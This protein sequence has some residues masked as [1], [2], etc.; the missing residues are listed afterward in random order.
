MADLEQRIALTDADNTDNTDNTDNVNDAGSSTSLTASSLLPYDTKTATYV[1]ASKIPN[2]GDGL[3]V[4]KHTARGTPIAVY[5]GAKIT[6]EEVFDLHQSDFE[7]YRQAN[8]VIRGTPN[9]FAVK[10]EKTDKPA[11]HGVYVNDAARIECDKANLTKEAIIEYAK[12]AKDCNVTTQNTSD[13]PVYV[14]RK[15][16]A[17]N[18]E[19]Y[20][21]YGIGYWLQEIGCTADEISK[22]NVALKFDSLY[23]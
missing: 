2:A 13:Y 6:D 7:A 12:T 14:T 1:K 8:S 20:A 16:V 10:G 21:H 19:L 23:A 17:K 4:K 3:F 15:R 18:E 22:L 9:G 11:L 5:Y